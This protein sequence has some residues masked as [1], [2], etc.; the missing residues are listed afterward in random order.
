MFITDSYENILGGFLSV[1]YFHYEITEY[2]RLG[3]SR[4]ILEILAEAVAMWARVIEK[5]GL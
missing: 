5:R 3:F 1:K 2:L 4:N